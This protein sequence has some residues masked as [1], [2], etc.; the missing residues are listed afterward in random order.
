MDACPCRTNGPAPIARKGRRAWNRPRETLRQEPDN[1]FCNWHVAPGHNCAAC[2]PGVVWERN[3][4]YD[5]GVGRDR[6][7]VILA[8]HPETAR[9]WEERNGHDA[10]A[11]HC[12]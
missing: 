5:R 9:Q 8:R 6:P 7:W 2:A 3:S 4:R 11:Q 10:H 1:G 12:A